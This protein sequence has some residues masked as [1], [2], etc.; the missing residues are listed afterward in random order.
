MSASDGSDEDGVDSDAELQVLC[1]TEADKT[2]KDKSRQRDTLHE[3]TRNLIGEA[4]L[5]YQKVISG[6]QSHPKNPSSDCRTRGRSSN[7][8]C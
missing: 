7:D 6:T 3:T 4:S 2:S 8:L 1:G 5:F